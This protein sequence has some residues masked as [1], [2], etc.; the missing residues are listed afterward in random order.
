MEPNFLKIE[1]PMKNENIAVL[2]MYAW[3]DKLREGNLSL[4]ALITQLPHMV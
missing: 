2:E 1:T 4:F 3:K